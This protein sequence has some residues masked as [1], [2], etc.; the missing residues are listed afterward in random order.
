M[1]NAELKMQNYGV[2]F[3]D[4]QDLS[5]QAIPQFLICNSEF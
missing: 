4:D 1:Q 3:A 2:G 5:P